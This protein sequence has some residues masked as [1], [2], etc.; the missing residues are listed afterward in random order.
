MSKHGKLLEKLCAS[1]TP[2]NLKWT[3]L[4]VVLEH[5]GYKMLKPGKSG[6][7]RRKFHHTETGLVIACHKPHPSPHVDKGCIND[8][9]QHLKENGIIE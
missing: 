9:V 4:K 5:L 7:S 1:P 2:A 8:I 3:E 6:G